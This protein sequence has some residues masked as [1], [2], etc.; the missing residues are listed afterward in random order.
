MKGSLLSEFAQSVFLMA[1]MA[2]MVGAY[3]GIGLL[4]V[5]MLG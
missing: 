5:R 3:L 2:L 1:L 4:A